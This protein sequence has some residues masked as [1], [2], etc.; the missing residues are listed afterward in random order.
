MPKPFK[1]P[2]NN[3]M[4]RAMF[5]VGQNKEQSQN[6]IFCAVITVSQSNCRILLSISSEGF[7]RSM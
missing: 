2:L 6:F 3:V 1:G 5:E 7:K 4:S